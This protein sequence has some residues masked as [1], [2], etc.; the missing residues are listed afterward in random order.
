LFDLVYA[1]SLP[2]EPKIN[3]ADVAQCSKKI[4]MRPNRGA[5]ACTRSDSRGQ[6]SPYGMPDFVQQR[7]MQ[8]MLG[9][10]MGSAGFGNASGH[11][12][13]HRM[14]TLSFADGVEGRGEHPDEEMRLQNGAGLQ[15]CGADRGRENRIAGVVANVE[16]FGGKFHGISGEGTAPAHSLMSPSAKISARQTIQI[17]PVKIPDKETIQATPVKIPDALPIQDTRVESVEPPA[18]S[19]PITAK[20][21]VEDATAT[22]LLA[23]DS[24]AAKKRD[25]SKAGKAAIAASQAAIAAAAA[26]NAEA[27]NEVSA[28]ESSVA[29]PKCNKKGALTSS[30]DANMPAKKKNKMKRKAKKLK[31]TTHFSRVRAESEAHLSSVTASVPNEVE[32]SRTSAPSEGKRPTMSNEKSRNQWLV[33]SGLAASHGAGQNKVFKYLSGNAASEAGAKKSA[34]D[35]LAKIMLERGFA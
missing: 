27:K 13:F 6:T 2:V 7:A 31:K 30:A 15:L 5:F 32:R 18:P 24:R 26:A 16:R 19:Q 4:N 29:L 3:M 35:A 12:L 22:I 20:K 10:A 34:G 8:L 23:L 1:D 14:P 21:S 11:G 33:R 9:G 25:N 28:P 17:T